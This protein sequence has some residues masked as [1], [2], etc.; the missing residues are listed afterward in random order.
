MVCSPSSGQLHVL[1]FIKLGY[2]WLLG[3][4]VLIG[5]FK[6]LIFFFNAVFTFHTGHLSSHKRLAFPALCSLLVTVT[7]RLGQD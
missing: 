1:H 4:G 5:I 3:L 6:V 2:C 7:C